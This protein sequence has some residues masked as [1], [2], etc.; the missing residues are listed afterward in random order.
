[1]AKSKK[2]SPSK[3]VAN[4]SAKFSTNHNYEGKLSIVIP[5][6][7]EDERVEM[8]SK[9]LQSFE[10]IWKTP[11]EVIFVN[12]GSS[13]NT[14]SYLQNNY[15]ET[16][17]SSLEYKIIDVEKN[18]GKGN[19]LKVGVLAAEGDHIL[20]LDADMAASPSNLFRWLGTLS[21]QTFSDNQILIASRENEDSEV[22]QKEGS[23]RKLLGNFFNYWVQ[24]LT[25]LNQKDT[26][27][28][29]KLYPKEIG[30]WLFSGMKTKGWAHDV[31]LLHKAHLHEVEIVEMP[32]VWKEVDQS[33]VSVGLDGIKMG[34]TSFGISLL[35]NF[36]YF[37]TDAIKELKQP[38]PI[39]QTGNMP[40]ARL[41]FGIT[42]LLLLIA[43]PTL[44]SDFGITGDEVLQK[45]YGDDILAYYQSGG[46]N[47]KCLE[48]EL[49]SYYGGL[50][51]YTSS[52]LA[53]IFPNA[54]VYDVR[55][56]FNSL[57][58]FIAILFIGLTARKLTGR[59]SGAIIAILFMVLSPRFFGHSM[60]NP[61]DIPFAT[62]FVFTIYYLMDY[63]KRF[64]KVSMQT[65][66]WLVVGIGAAINMRVGGIL[67]IA[68]LFMFHGLMELEQM[69]KKGLNFVPFLTNGI[70][71]VVTAFAG[72]LLGLWFWPFGWLDPVHNPFKALNELTNFSTGIKVLYQ[73]ENIWSDRIPWHYTMTWMLYT[74]PLFVLG[75]FVLYPI[76]LVIDKLQKTQIKL[77]AAF[78][79][80]AIFPLA[81]AIYK[82]S[83][84]YDGLRHFLFVYALFA[85]MAACTWT[86]LF[87]GKFSSK[88]T[89]IGL[90]IGLAVLMALPIRFM[91][92]NHP[93]QYTYFNEVAGGIDKVKYEFETDYWMTSMKRLSEKMKSMTPAQVDK[94]IVIGTNSYKQLKHYFKDDERFIISYV[95]YRDRIKKNWDYGLF[96]NRFVNKGF[97]DSGVFPP[98]GTIHSEK[99]DGVPI[100][101]ICENTYPEKDQLAKFLKPKQKG[102]SPNQYMQRLVS[103]VPL[104]E[105]AIQLDPMNESALATVIQTKAQIGDF[106]TIDKQLNQ[107]LALSDDYPNV[108][109]IKAISLL[110]Q[111]KVD[112]AKIL[113]ERTVELDY[114]FTFAY[115]HLARILDAQK[116]YAQALEYLVQFDKH[117]GRPGNGYDLG[118]AVAKKGNNR[119]LQL[120]FQAKKLQLTN[121]PKAHQEAYKLLQQVVIMDPE[122][123]NAAKLKKSYDDASAKAKAKKN[124]VDRS[125]IF[126]IFKTLLGQ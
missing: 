120:Y 30:H 126:G 20:T 118:I 107:A 60:N 80:C 4:P 17:E 103:S 77:H 9:T 49:L 21:D 110:N 41:L 112:S 105:Q 109:S 89:R 102:E 123:E 111:N 99:V 113:F 50:F 24:F 100:G 74:T 115:F 75:G 45:N 90:G 18:Q 44:S 58:G 95:K 78:V 36:R 3:K 19:A 52:I 31:E 62:A 32:I 34:F 94:P 5:L 1:M 25:G 26:Q 47:Q 82:G 29:F 124:K 119:M 114:K 11:C 14:L 69:R 117:G 65:Y 55:H 37:F 39:S 121:K 85:C 97:L 106:K 76:T 79:F 86:A 83:A 2:K 16:V 87:F 72:Y 63:I 12:D 68:F 66:I 28:G 15:G 61:K 27:C 8:M 64:Q 40:L 91:V 46:K 56:A 116:Q 22:T 73:G 84:L 59:W 101:I 81:Y 93:Y 88:V 96:Y 23:R 104:L 43:M 54:D 38:S 92:T 13:D 122:F 108:L 33:K 98:K 71:V 7:N 67:L 48:W 42:A 53:G 70:K 6:Y 51:D 125:G 10:N 57:F 35:N